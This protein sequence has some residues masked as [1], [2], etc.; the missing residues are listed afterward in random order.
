MKWAKNKQGFTIVE[1]LIVVVV[2]AILAAITVVAYNGIQN[3]S[4]DA[5]VKSEVSVARK[6]IGVFAAANNDSFPTTINS[7]PTPVTGAVCVLKDSK[8]TLAYTG[9]PSTFCFSAT[10]A[11][12]IA[13]Y[14]TESGIVTSGGCSPRSCYQIQQAGNSTGDGVY[15]IQPGGSGSLVPAYCD[16]TIAGGGWTLLV[17]NP[18]PA[19]SWNGTNVYSLN[20]SS[21]SPS[22]LYSNLNQANGIKSN[23]GGTVNY[24]MDAVTRGR[25]G[26]VWSAPYSVDL[27]STVPQDKATLIQQFD[28]WTQ[29]T[30]SIDGNGTQTPSNVVPWVSSVGTSPGLTTWGNTG[31]W[32]GTLVTYS[33]WNPAPWINTGQVNPG[34]IWYWVR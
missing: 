20:T 21:P 11:S 28:T 8:N 27:Q 12:G 23:I 1:L 14:V 19:T 9:T 18:G 32:Y 16:M 15:S 30:N 13:Y 31:N 6:Q 5:V 3:R 29:D 22:S 34:V 2:I 25:W 24:M 4:R 10:D 17:S 26:G 7:C 33:V